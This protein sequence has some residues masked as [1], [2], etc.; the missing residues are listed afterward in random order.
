[1]TLSKRL[2]FLMDDRGVGNKELS[3]RSGVPLRTINNI[4]SGV[5]NNP[6]LETMRAIAKALNCTLDD[7]AD[8]V[9][10]YNNA[11]DLTDYLD[12]LHKRPE[13][14]M[15]FS[16]AKKATKEDVEKAVKII[17]MLKGDNE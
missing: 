14:K 5:T 17:E 11:D 10:D 12:E 8:T 2:K 9:S 3:D 1:M 13:M 7:F 16:V 4:I 6:T 15:L